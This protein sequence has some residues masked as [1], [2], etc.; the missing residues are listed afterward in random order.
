MGTWQTLVT[1][2]NGLLTRYKMGFQLDLLIESSTL[3]GGFFIEWI[4]K[5][6]SVTLVLGS[7]TRFVCKKKVYGTRI[8]ISYTNTI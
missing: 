3:E 7:T 2:A 1:W 8:Q 6:Q 5:D 4:E